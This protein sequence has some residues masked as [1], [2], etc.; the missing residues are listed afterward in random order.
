MNDWL[1]DA[2][3]YEIYPQSFCDSNGDGIGD[4]R[5]IISKLDYI[6][7]LGC[8]AIWMNPCY[9]S[10]FVDAGYDVRDY[11]KVAERYGTLD[12]I[13]ELF[14]EIHKRGMHILTDLVPG[15]TSD[16]CEW[17]RMSAKDEK[18]EY[19]DRYIWTDNVWEGVGDIRN[20]MGMSRGGTERNGAYFANFFNAQ[21]ALNYGFANI[22]P[23]R[24]WQ[25]PVT[26]EGPRATVEAIKDVM[27]YWLD[28]G[29]DGFRVDMAGSLIKSD[30]DQTENMKLW[31]E[32]R[33]F[34]DDE[35]P[36]AAIVS[37]WGEP[38]KSI[39]AGFHMDF[40][41]HFGPSHYLDLFRVEH[42]FFSREGKGNAKAFLDLYMRNL[43]LAREHDGFICIPSGNHDMIRMA[44]TLDPEEMKIA[45][46]FIMTM[47]GIPFVYYGDEIGMK[48]VE[49]L[50]SVEGG[51]ERTGSRS[52]MAFDT[53]K[54][55]GFSS[56][57]PED[58]YIRQDE[59]KDKINVETEEK[60]E[61]SLLNEVKALIGLRNGHDALKAPS[62]IEI[63]YVKEND[64]P[65]AYRRKSADESIL[66][67]LN[68]S[69]R[70]VSLDFELPEK[71]EVL[72]TVGNIKDEKI[73]PDS[74]PAASAIV[75]KEL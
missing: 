21:P 13:R 68:P 26:A 35:Y 55:A 57:D 16:Q 1:N 10:P 9:D 67:I 61:A 38:D 56:A 54:N 14:D 32:F 22:D 3:F 52:P 42:P 59:S 51:Y 23:E 11:Y 71:Y 40:V 17:F 37:E 33:Q 24:S 62:D 8:N 27:R 20:I 47:P 60:D 39:A 63:V 43:E 30:P 6:R 75:L 44:K 65:L 74:F 34:L 31:R 64:Y 41:L 25:Q 19:T 12:D 7:D 48:Y 49:G 50:K 73:T 2:V 69:G 36:D 15:H 29:C 72:H 70:E 18:N 58:L 28:L 66:V 45:Y 46:A 53:T 5:G 4:F